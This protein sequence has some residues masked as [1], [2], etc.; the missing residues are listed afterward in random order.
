MWTTGRVAGV[1]FEA[2]VGQVDKLHVDFEK[3]RMLVGN[4]ETGVISSCDPLT[5]RVNKDVVFCAE[6]RHPIQLLSLKMNGH[7]GVA[8]REDGTLTVI[9]KLKEGGALVTY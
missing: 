6:E 8:G 4:M 2:K 1:Q 9:N 5:G 3:N 7:R